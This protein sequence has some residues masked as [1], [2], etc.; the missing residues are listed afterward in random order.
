MLGELLSELDFSTSGFNLFAFFGMR[1]T[2]IRPW[3]V[4][5]PGFAYFIIA[6]FALAVGTIR[7][8]FQGLVDV[9]KLVKLLFTQMNSDVLI[10]N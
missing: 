8:S 4:I 2:H 5:K 9:A 6:I 10:D 7:D 1:E 3:L